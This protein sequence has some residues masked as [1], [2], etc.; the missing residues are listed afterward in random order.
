MPTVI[1]PLINRDSP[2]RRAMP[3]SLN[4]PTP[5]SPEAYPPT[6]L[7]TRTSTNAQMNPEAPNDHKRK[8][9]AARRPDSR[10]D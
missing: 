7:G 9:R 6:P 10:G 8:V 3:N 2:T 1:S 5:A 4:P